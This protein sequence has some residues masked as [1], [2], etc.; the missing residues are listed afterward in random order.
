MGRV[1]A[2]FGLSMRNFAQ[3]L[4]ALI[5]GW[6]LFP[7]IATC[8]TADGR[9]ERS[10]REGQAAM[11]QGQFARAAEDFKKVLQLDP[12]LIEAEV[13]LGLAYQGLLEYDSATHYLV[14][15][16][17]E[18][19]NLLGPTVIV[20]MDYVKLGS[21]EKGIPFLRTALELDPS[22]RDA[23]EALASSYLNQDNFQDAAEQFRQIA[24][25]ISDKSEAW[26]RLGHEYL[27][28]S[29]RLAYRGAHLYPDSAWG[30]RFLGDLVYQRSHWQHAVDEYQK[31]L[32]S[33]PQ[34]PGLHEAMGRAWLHA[35]NLEQS[36]TELRS[37][38]QLDPRSES[39][40]LSLAGCHLARNQTSAALE[41]LDRVWQISSDFL[42]V[43]REFPPIELSQESTRAMIAD[44]QNK[45][46]T[47]PKHFLLAALF[48]AVSDTA[49]ADGE[50]KSFQGQFSLWQKQTPDPSGDRDPCQIHA[51]SRCIVSLAGRKQLTTYEWL[52]LGK[53][54]LTLQQ[55]QTAAEALSQVHGTASENAEASYWLER[56]YQA[57][58]AETYAQLG[59][60]FP[61]S[62]RTHQLRAESYALSGSVQDALSEFQAALALRPNEPELHEALGELYLDGN[63]FAEAQHEL[64]QTLAADTSRT[65]AL[66][67]LGR[68]FVEQKDNEKALPYLEKAL[69]IQP[70]L[71]EANSLLG[72]AYLRLGQPANAVSKL[73]KAA[74]LDHY[75]SVHYQLFVAYRKL[76]Q[77]E[78]AQKELLLSQKLR[79]SNLE[80]EQALITGSSHSETEPQ[81]E[82]VLQN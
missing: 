9:I 18:R 70:D 6:P 77:P 68:V 62:W 10:F 5:A 32:T 12:G 13:N 39:A 27:D 41:D 82:P 50:W 30:H 38:L 45:P 21:P 52:E 29:G 79:K 61:N 31:A 16:L 14:K 71:A 24:N 58:G 51:Y 64:E 65:H 40:W 46:E 59:D 78:R 22:N 74:P 37:E 34:Q 33:E 11:Q 26:F 8:E 1:A 55:Y 35:G 43:Q 25:R 44:I 28:L 60:S 20:G 48:K 81:I 57:L 47:A 53:A 2:L 36:E 49:S 72:T 19:P 42:A 69:R 23:R 4:L 54:R 15:A 7:S 17:R 73:M 80:R 76:G 67:L 75:G 56:T 3:V 63:N 66:Y